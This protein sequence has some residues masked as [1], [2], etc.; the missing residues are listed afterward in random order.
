MKTSLRLFVLTF[1]VSVLSLALFFTPAQAQETGVPAVVVLTSKGPITPVMENYLERGLTIA[2]QQ[3]A[4]VV[5]LQL[6]TPG[7]S[8]DLMNNIVQTIRSST[9][10]I[11]VYVSPRGA[12][13]GS[14]GTIITLSAHVAAMAPQTTIG[15]AS[16]VGSQG[17]DIGTTMESKVKEM[18]KAEVR[19][20]THER[21]EEATRLAEDTIENARAVTEE[22][23]LKSGLVDIVASDLPD[24]INKLDGREVHLDSAALVLR[25]RGAV[26]LP[27]KNTFIE[28][29]LLFIVNP[30]LV[31]VLLA[32]GVQAI[33]IEL[34]NPGAWIPGFIGVVCILLA[35]Y[36]LGVLPVNWFGL[37]FIILAF[38][39]FLLEI[40]TPVHGTMAVAGAITFVIGALVLFNSVRLPGFP[41]VSVPLVL[42]TAVFLAFSFLGIVSFALRAQRMP[43]RMGK[44][45]LAG[46]KG[47]AR[48][49]LNP[50]G[51]VIIGGEAWSAELEPG[52]ISLPAGGAIEVIRVEGIHLIV[53]GIP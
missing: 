46:K 36:G 8:I 2:K 43:I 44:E 5:I 15:A 39:L 1:L 42:G 27:V 3:R 40:K 25:T 26:Q 47:T 18:M 29:V 51:T 32:V 24:L 48:T 10:P 41:G 21:G 16:P 7:G 38:A 11:V 13:A 53:R 34:T 50:Y 49:A 6:D 31:F 19:T 35:I 23:A 28:E 17:E 14:A 52:S 12:M 45:T 4:G 37:L 30:N 20:L 33:L 22:E 9:I